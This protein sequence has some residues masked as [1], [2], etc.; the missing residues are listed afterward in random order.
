MPVEVEPC[1]LMDI[2]H[3]HPG[4]EEP[5]ELWLRST[6]SAYPNVPLPPSSLH[7]CSLVT[8]P[9]PPPPTSTVP[10]SA[11]LD[12]TPPLPPVNPS[13]VPSVPPSSGN[14]KRA[15]SGG[16]P[17]TAQQTLPQQRYPPREVPPRFRQQEHKQL[18]KRGQPLPSGTLPLT[19]T[20]RPATTEPAAAVATH[21]SPSC[22]SSST[23]S[24]PT[25]QPRHYLLASQYL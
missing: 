22:S 16:Q 2:K 25:G 23:S 11:K 10:E 1:L 13:A 8:C 24:L 14:G 5:N 4:V 20:G 3:Q 9:P 19:T 12:P 7:F 17:Q 18:L 15:P 21:S 6:K